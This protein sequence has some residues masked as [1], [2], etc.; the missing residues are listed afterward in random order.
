MH[1]LIYSI[2]PNHRWEGFAHI[3]LYC[4]CQT[5]KQQ[6]HELV[7]PLSG[8]LNHMAVNL[9]HVVIELLGVSDPTLQKAC[10]VGALSLPLED[11]GW[12]YLNQKTIFNHM[13]DQLDKGSK[14]LEALRIVE[15]A[16]EKNEDPFH[17]MRWLRL[18]N[19]ETEN[20]QEHE[21]NIPFVGVQKLFPSYVQHKNMA[22]AAFVQV[23]SKFCDEVLFEDV[24]DNYKMLL[25]KYK[26]TR[27]QYMN[28]MLS[29]HCK[30]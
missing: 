25:E 29:L 21:W 8:V 12:L 9:L 5:E 4:W 14:F 16:I 3:A 28:G 11:N 1:P 13:I 17:R 24:I 26:K 7:E 23:K 20:T 15:V 10:L 30:S 6:H 18:L 22:E 19:Q 2:L 27:K